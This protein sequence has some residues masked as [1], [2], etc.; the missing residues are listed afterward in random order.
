MLLIGVFFGILGQVV[1]R[2]YLGILCG[3]LLVILFTAY[4]L[5]LNQ[6]EGV[7]SG[8][9]AGII[10]GVIAAAISLLIGGR[11]DTPLTGIVYGLIR[12]ALYGAI[13]GLVTR[14]QSDPEDRL[15]TK[16]FLLAGSI[17]LG[18][19]LGGSVG[20]INGL[21]LGLIDD[22]IA[23]LIIITVLGAVVG[24]YLTPVRN[25]WLFMVIAFFVGGGTAVLAWLF[26]GI[27]VGMA[28][29]ILSGAITPMLVVALIGAYGGLAARGPVA[30]IIEAVEAPRELVIQDPVP[31]L[32][33]SILVGLLVGTTAQGL[34][35]L[36]ALPAILGAVGLLLGAIREVEKRPSHRV[37][38]QTLIDVIIIG[39]D[40]WPIQKVTKLLIHPTHR[41]KL[42]VGTI[43]SLLI[44]IGGGGLGLLTIKALT[45]LIDTLG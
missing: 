32:A 20:A 23:G 11:H 27:P 29:G 17:L 16:L 43:V 21:F 9:I 34:S 6:N 42:A 12:G 44:S 24:S 33:P 25:Q 37:T 18:A 4:T 39:A 41:K 5:T 19:V 7:W 45:Q 40:K 26:G 8:L 10:L 13:A 22:T 38:A 2:P 28:V 3:I 15:L 36:L 31:Y 30:M 35:S 1:E 14:V